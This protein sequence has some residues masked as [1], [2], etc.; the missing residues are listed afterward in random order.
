MQFSFPSCNR[1]T[2]MQI[3]LVVVVVDCMKCKI[4]MNVKDS[5]LTVVASLIKFA[6]NTFSTPKCNFPFPIGFFHCYIIFKS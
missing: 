3:K 2:V 4:R 5:Q 6:L 1:F